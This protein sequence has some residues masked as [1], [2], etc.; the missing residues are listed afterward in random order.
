M[1]FLHVVQVG[2][3]LTTLLPQSAERWDV[4]HHTWLVIIK[5]SY[6]RWYIRP[7]LR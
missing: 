5:L 1:G 6:L 3:E 7:L 4:H 2:L